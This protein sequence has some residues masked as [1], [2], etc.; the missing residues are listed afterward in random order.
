MTS[1]VTW[2]LAMLPSGWARLWTYFFRTAKNHSKVNIIWRKIG[3]RIPIS[4]TRWTRRCNIIL[5]NDGGNIISRLTILWKT[6][7]CSFSRLVGSIAFYEIALRNAHSFMIF[8]QTLSSRIPLNATGS[9]RSVRISSLSYLVASLYLKSSL[10][11]PWYYS[12]IQTYFSS[13]ACLECSR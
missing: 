13:L 11:G 3:P 6:S 5:K 1:F 10:T 7:S 9:Y 4:F 8:A 12:N 2:P